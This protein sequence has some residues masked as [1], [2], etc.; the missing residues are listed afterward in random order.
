MD[1]VHRLDPSISCPMDSNS[2]GDREQYS[3]I[4][5]SGHHNH[6]TFALATDETR[7]GKTELEMMPLADTVQAQ[8]ANHPL[9]PYLLSAYLDCRK[10]GAP[11]EMAS[12]LEVI[13]KGNHP[14]SICSPAGIGADPELDAFMKWYCEILHKYKEKLS[15]PFEEATSFLRSIESQLS[16]LCKETL[17]EL[18][19]SNSCLTTCPNYAAPDDGCGRSNEDI[20]RRKLNENQDY[21]QRREV[22]CELKEML[23]RKHRG[24]LS[25]LRKEFL[26]QR[27]KGKLPEDARLALL[28]WWNEH[29][30]WPYPTE[31]EK[32]KL[33]DVTGLDQKQI[34]NWFVNQRK[35]HWRPLDDSR[36]SVMDGA[37]GHL[38]I[39]GSTYLGENLRHST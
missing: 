37:N 13:S 2:A 35:R 32:N 31:E 27:K 26:K 11:P 20:H 18:N 12:V 7:E 1:E 16:N 28:D 9:Y 4:R 36:F 33:S 8:I 19:V 6:H 5:L 25:S 22:D 23:M 30:R 3:V 29:Y 21:T 39:A 15:K 10:V 24:Y 14:I 17:H 38:N 34:N